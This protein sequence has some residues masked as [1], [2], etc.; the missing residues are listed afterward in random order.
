MI[1]DNRIDYVRQ[2]YTLDK[3]SSGSQARLVYSQ[4]L[5]SSAIELEVDQGLYSPSFAYSV[6]LSLYLSAPSFI[7]F[8]QDI[9]LS[10]L[11]AGSREWRCIIRVHSYD[12]G[13]NLASFS[14]NEVGRYAVLFAPN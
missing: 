7:N 14:V 11:D 9:C 6:T 4:A 12:E 2:F 8:N 1:P 3:V 5:V 10:K 13:S